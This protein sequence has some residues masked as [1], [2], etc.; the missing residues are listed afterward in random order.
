MGYFLDRARR[1]AVLASGGVP[2]SPAAEAVAASVDESRFRH[3]GPAPRS[4]EAAILMLADGVEAA[5][6]SLAEPDEA[7][8]RA[9]VRRIVD[10]RL[11]DGQLDGT[12]LTLRDLERIR[13]AFIGQ[14]RG[15]WHRRV[16]YPQN[17]LVADE[18]RGSPPEP[19]A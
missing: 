1:A 12:D 4:R 13:E 2:G 3:T 7:A 14:L 18:L 16:A 5:V 15:I 6:R 9:M 19:G 8:I 10:E 11:E 17:A